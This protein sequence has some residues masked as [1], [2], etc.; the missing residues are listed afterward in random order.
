[1]FENVKRRN[2]FPKV[3]THIPSASVAS[4]ARNATHSVA[5]GLILKKTGSLFPLNPF[6]L[7]FKECLPQTPCFLHLHER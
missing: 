3:S 4:P 5:G 7:F 1:L 2:Y 6:S